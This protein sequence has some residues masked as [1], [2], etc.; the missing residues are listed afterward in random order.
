MVIASNGE[1]SSSPFFVRDAKLWTQGSFAW[2]EPKSEV[3]AQSAT[4]TL[5]EAIVAFGWPF[6]PIISL[7]TPT[8]RNGKGFSEMKSQGGRCFVVSMVGVLGK[9]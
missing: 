2:Q 4:I 6:R 1:V 7:S 3:M 5:L 8:S 9:V